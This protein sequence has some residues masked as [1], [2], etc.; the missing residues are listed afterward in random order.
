MEVMLV[1]KD[2]VEI[3]VGEWHSQSPLENSRRAPSTSVL[4]SYHYESIGAICSIEQK[5]NRKC[6]RNLTRF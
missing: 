2:E 6:R 1:E 5:Q 3:A 4:S